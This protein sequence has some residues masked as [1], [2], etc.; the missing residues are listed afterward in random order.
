MF[1]SYCVNLGLYVG[2]AEAYAQDNIDDLLD[3]DDADL[4]GEDA[5]EE[6]PAE[7]MPEEE[8][9][10][11][12]PQAE[13][14]PEPQPEQPAEDEEI[15]DIEDDEEDIEDIEDEEDA[16]PAEDKPAEP[17][18]DEEI[19][20]IEDEEVEDIDDDEAVAEKPA[21][22]APE[23]RE[24]AKIGPRV[25][26]PDKISTYI[27]PT[28]AANERRSAEVENYVETWL[29]ADKRFNY[30]PVNYSMGDRSALDE[31]VQVRK[32]KVSLD[33]GISA[34]EGV[35][36]T[37]AIENLNNAIDL[38]R[39]FM[40]YFENRD[41]VIE[42]TKYLAASYVLLGDKARGKDTFYT[43]L[44]LQPETAL[45]SD[46]FPATVQDV[47]N[48]AKSSN[49]SQATSSLTVET[50][51]KGAMVFL[52]GDFRGLTPITLS[53][54]PVGE[55]FLKVKSPGYQ[56]YRSKIS[57]YEDVTKKVD[58]PTKQVTRYYPYKAEVND[59]RKRYEHRYMWTPVQSLANNV[60]KTK[61]LFIAS[62]SE[63]RGVVE[64][65]GYYYNLETEEYKQ[66]NEK[67]DTVSSNLDSNVYAYMNRLFSDEVAFATCY[68]PP[69]QLKEEQEEE[70]ETPLY[71]QW[72][73]WTIVGV[74]VAG[75]VAGI[76]AW[77]LMD[78]GGGDKTNTEPEFQNPNAILITF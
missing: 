35:D 75:G 61:H 73:L 43:L 10:A 27:F 11:E 31:N 76:V 45:D 70:E 28:T 64:I 3:V 20:D 36:L 49:S 23:P 47:F 41:A 12:K 2:L 63:S 15:E 14:E 7:A 9:P 56:E 1:I 55:H 19:E 8:A 77:Q 25:D 69:E 22:K 48:D 57:L 71:A 51:R 38:Y 21:R 78:D 5:A 6:S 4:L 13:P 53:S 74:V 33:D 37:V 59:I 34:Y 16:P 62:V 29:R 32:A 65:D 40:E 66:L 54:L 24:V 18:E 72:W 68:V 58:V 52:D 46:V 26:G 50:A 44:W 42:A 39:P 30:R 17:A 60:L 67:M